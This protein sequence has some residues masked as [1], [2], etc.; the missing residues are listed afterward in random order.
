MEQLA[1]MR[2]V[3]TRDMSAGIASGP[4]TIAD[5]KGGFAIG[6]MPT[7][8][9][10]ATW[11]VP[12]TWRS[13]PA[14]RRDAGP[15]EW[16]ITACTRIRLYDDRREWTAI[17]RDALPRPSSTAMMACAPAST[18]RTICTA[19]RTRRLIRR[20]RRQTAGSCHES[21]PQCGH[22]RIEPRIQHKE[23][24]PCVESLLPSPSGM[25][26]RC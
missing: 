4:A 14:R 3:R 19:R 23:A 6:A 5:G 2:W 10:T 26:R 20:L 12:T 1:E 21:L 25:S 7:A 9:R 15:L 17:S 18:R 11:R 24:L 8:C 16:P 22:L 13:A